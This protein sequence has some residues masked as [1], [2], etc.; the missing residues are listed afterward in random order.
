MPSRGARPE[1]GSGLVPT[2]N[3]TQHKEDLS[4]KIK[5]QKIVVDELSNL[6]KNRKVYRQQQN[7]DIFFL[8]DRT[9]MLSESKN[10][11]DELRKEYQE[12]ENSEKTK[13]KK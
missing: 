6:K 7:S 4:S 13:I 8:A 1:D 12:I 10:T 11:L 3:S 5:E 2:D 9:E